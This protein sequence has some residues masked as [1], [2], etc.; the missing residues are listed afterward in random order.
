MSKNKK[1]LFFFLLFVFL[2]L[3]TWVVLKNLNFSFKKDS[4]PEKQN[5]QKDFFSENTFES[6]E[7]IIGQILAKKLDIAEDKVSTLIAQESNNHVVGLYFISISEKETEN[8]KFFGIINDSVDI[9]WYGD[10][11]LDCEVLLKN[12]FSQEMIPNCF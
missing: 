7:K 10:K 3:I 9:I 1:V 6:R 12:N 8:G 2:I 11:N 4:F 5:I